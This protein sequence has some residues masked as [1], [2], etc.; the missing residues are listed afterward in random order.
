MPDVCGDARYGVACASITNFP[1]RVRAA[2]CATRT[3]TEA[4]SKGMEEILLHCVE[5]ARQAPAAVLVAVRAAHRAH[6]LPASVVGALAALQDAGHPD[7]V[8]PP[9]A[10]PAPPVALLRGL[11]WRRRARAVR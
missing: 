7:R 9:V 1:S 6:D 4:A 3:A 11:L 2:A 10:E 5:D 8:P